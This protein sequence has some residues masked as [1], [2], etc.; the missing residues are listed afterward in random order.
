MWGWAQQDGNSGRDI[1][2]GDCVAID[3]FFHHLV[4]TEYL[5]S[6]SKFV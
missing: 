4:F 2:T 1:Y 5:F 3:I 6:S